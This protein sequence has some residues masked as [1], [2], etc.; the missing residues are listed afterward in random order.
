MSTAHLKFIALGV[1]G[2]ALVWA[3]RALLPSGTDRPTADF[4]LPAV[5]RDS[6]DTIAVAAP[7]ETVTVA[8]A[9]GVWTVNGFAASSTAVEELFA[10]LRD[11]VQPELVARSATS[12]TR[13]GVDT[14]AARRLTVRA[15]GRDVLD[16]LVSE[17]GTGAGGAYVRLPTDS[18]VYAWTG[19]LAPVVRRRPDDWRNRVVGAVTPD[20]IRRV[21]VA[22]GARTY[23]LRRVDGPW[24][25]AGGAPVDSAAVARLVNG[26]RT[27]N[28]G[29]FPTRAQLDSAFRGRPERRV[30]LFG[31]PPA[32]TALLTLEFD[33]TA[34]GFWVRR[35]GDTTV[36]RL[37][38]WETDLLTPADSTLKNK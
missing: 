5:A 36:Y 18:A 9:Q 13:L 19:N 12:F 11:T 35:A 24:S 3:G 20:S 32:D 22:R 2:L 8:R 26:F 21:D 33:S 34:G 17:R 29:S 30:T 25:F 31:A 23:S 7:L 1:L 28:A 38:I 16:L 10:A 37:G 14:G 6:V 27:V 4:R 15:Q